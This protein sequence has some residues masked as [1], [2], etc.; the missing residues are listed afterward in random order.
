MCV[1]LTDLSSQ[2]LA[3]VLSCGLNG[4]EN[5]SEEMWKL[6][7][8]KI[9]PVLGPALDLLADTVHDNTLVSVHLYAFQAM[10]TSRCTGKVKH[11][12]NN[13]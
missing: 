9:N 4:N 7:T 6:F 11:C 2:D 1:Q 5:V 12:N 10:L 3:T 8:Q 13:K